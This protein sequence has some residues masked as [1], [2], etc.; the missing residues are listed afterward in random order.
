M[1]KKYLLLVI[2]LA[3]SLSACNLSRLS[4]APSTTPFPSSSLSP[5]ATI[6]LPPSITPSP[7][8]TLT[9]TVTPTATI[10]LTPSLTPRP[11]AARVVIISVDG[12]RPDGLLRAEIPRISE[13]INGGASTFTARTILPSGTLPAHA[14]MVSGRCVSKH[15]IL[16]NDLIPSE[17]PLQ[18][19]TV[20]SIA[21][22]AGLRTVM[23]VGKEKLMTLAR[24]G[25]VDIFRWVNGSDEQIV[26]AALE[27]ASGGFGVLFVHLILPDFFGHS[28]GWMSPAYLAGIAR[29]DTAVGTLLD[30]LRARGLMDNALLIL[31]ADHGGHDRT[32]GT[33]QKEDMTIPWIIYGAGVLVGAPIDVPV[34][35]MD[36]AATAVWG[37]G[38]TVPSD[39]D[40][41]PVVEAFGLQADLLPVATASATRC[42]I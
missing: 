24:P 35:I 23:V 12:L 3:A 17:E 37:L 7:S 10:T 39:W 27:E 36:T 8:F 19:P 2:L 40:G 6:T 9:P 16:W 25:T 26:Q 5:T 1:R 4:P 28:D 13:L 34:S 42:G 32:H 14:S 15:G 11:A 38:L 33:Y 29:D 30:G 31:T 21:K 41:R 20:F 18:G 22:D